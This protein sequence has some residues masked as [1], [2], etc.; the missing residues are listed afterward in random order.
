M[1]V[2]AVGVAGTGS[3]VVTFLIGGPGFGGLPVIDSAAQAN[4]QDI[5]SGSH[6]YFPYGGY[7]TA[8]FSYTITAINLPTSFG[9]DNRPAGLSRNARTGQI[10]GT[11]T[12]PADTFQVPVSASVGAVTGNA[13]LTLTIQPATTSSTQSV[14]AAPAGALGSVDNPLAYVL[15]NSGFAPASALPTGLS[16]DPSTGLIAGYPASVGMYQIPLATPGAGSGGTAMLTLNVLA[17]D[18]LLP[19]LTGQVNAVVE[20]GP[21]ADASR[22]RFLRLTVV[23]P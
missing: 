22:Q 7:G 16:F 9:V 13:T 17:P 5:V 21:S 1:P 10:T 12:G 18:F 15:G 2:S 4:D 23:R 20:G 14:L 11:P 8:A 19:R 6:D 3:A